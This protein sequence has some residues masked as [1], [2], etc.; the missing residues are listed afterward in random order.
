[1][2]EFNF[3]QKRKKKKKVKCVAHKQVQQQHSSYFL[4]MGQNTQREIMKI[5]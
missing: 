1:M 2:A 4:V 3:W 5:Q